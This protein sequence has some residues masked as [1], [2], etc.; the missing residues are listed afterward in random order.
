MVGGGGGG[1]GGEFSLVMRG[2]G[3]SDGRTRQTNAC[4][5]QHLLSFSSALLCSAMPCSALICSALLC[6]PHI[7]SPLLCDET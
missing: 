5:G 7:A 4:A 2:E 1:R 3:R 6:S